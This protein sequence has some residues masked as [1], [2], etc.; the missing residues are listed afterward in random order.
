MLYM[1]AII[2]HNADVLDG[3]NSMGNGDG[4]VC[5]DGGRLYG[6]LNWAMCDWFGD[7]SCG[8]KESLLRLVFEMYIFA[9]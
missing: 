3:R 5:M 6:I 2:L 1:Y 8:I 7:S 9:T 4:K